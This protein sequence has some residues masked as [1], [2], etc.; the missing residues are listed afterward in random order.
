MPR[1]VVREYR[2][3]SSDAGDGSKGDGS[4]GGSGSGGHDRTGCSSTSK[5]GGGKGGGGKDGEPAPVRDGASESTTALFRDEAS[6]STTQSSSQQNRMTEPPMI[7][8]AV[9]GISVMPDCSMLMV[10]DKGPLP[11]CSGAG[12]DEGPLPRPDLAAARTRPSTPVP[13]PELDDDDGGKGADSKESGDEKGDGNTSRVHPPSSSPP[14]SAPPSP[15]GSDGEEDG[16]EDGEGHPGD[17]GTVSRGDAEIDCARVV[18]VAPRMLS[19]LWER[20]DASLVPRVPPPR[21]PA[22]ARSLPAP[23]PRPPAPLPGRAAWARR[24]RRRDLWS[25]RCVR[26]PERA[27][28]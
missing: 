18:A 22:P 7:A 1:L 23:R 6:E 16:E 11:R 17:D 21:E 26:E 3:G 20:V 27:G 19:P 8:T 10:N 2:D 12:N 4:K 15:P 14:P 24:A 13:L 5:D 25:R 9:T 28:P